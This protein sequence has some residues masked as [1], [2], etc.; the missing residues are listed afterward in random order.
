MTLDLVSVAETKTELNKLSAVDDVELAGYVGAA[1]EAIV[2]LTGPILPTSLVERHDGGDVEVLLRRC[3]VLSVQSVVEHSGAGAGVA[4]VE[5]QPGESGD[6][7]YLDAATAELT[8]VTGSGWAAGRTSWCPTPPATPQSR[9]ASDWRRCSSSSTCGG[10][11]STDPAVR[12][13]GSRCL[14]PPRPPTRCP[15]G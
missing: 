3:P 14:T 7:F 9:R 10:R 2:Y 5:R 6:G 12:S 1:S 13:P 4:V 8:R 11:A 15:G